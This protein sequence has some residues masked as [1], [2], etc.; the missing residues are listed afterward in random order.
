VLASTCSAPT[1]CWF[2]GLGRQAPRAWAEHEPATFNHVTMKRRRFVTCEGKPSD[3]R[4][5]RLFDDV[6]VRELADR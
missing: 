5:T 2:H 6:M 3:L 4:T 1:I